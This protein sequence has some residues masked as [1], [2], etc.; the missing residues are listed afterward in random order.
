MPVYWNLS[1]NHVVVVDNR[2]VFW[3]ALIAGPFFFFFIGEY[4][5]GLTDLILSALL[6]VVFLGWIVWIRYA[7]EAPSIVKDKWLSKGYIEE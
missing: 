7:F 3:C 1:T 6:W 5:H 2:R 4:L